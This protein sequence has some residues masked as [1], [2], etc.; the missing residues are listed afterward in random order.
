MGLDLQEA[1]NAR[2]VEDL[3][4]YQNYLDKY[5]QPL[6]KT[7]E[8]AIYTG[9]A[10]PPEYQEG[11]QAR[12]WSGAQAP[13]PSAASIADP[14]DASVAPP[15]ATGSSS[16]SAPSANPALEI[17]LDAAGN[18]LAGIEPPSTSAPRAAAAPPEV[19]APSPTAAAAD[20][21]A[22][23]SGGGPGTSTAKGA[24]AVSRQVARRAASGVDRALGSLDLGLGEAS[25]AGLIRAGAAAR[26]A[27]MPHLGRGLVRLGGVARY[28]APAMAA[29]GAVLPAVFGAMEGFNQ[30][31]VG[32]GVIQGGTSL[33]GAAAGA[34][35]G[36]AILPGIGTAIGAGLGSMA[37]SGVG[38]ALTSGAAGLVEKAQAG[39]TGWAGGIGRALDPFIDT[40]FEK[41]QTAALQQM[42]SPAMRLIRDQENA[43]L[44]RARADQA[45]AVLM[46][47]YLQE[48]R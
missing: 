12:A 46:Q 3:Y 34:A 28:A 18:S 44:E 2:I 42:N 11:F 33:G 21:L 15:V 4:D 23:L 45:Q 38:S 8:N 20:E 14:W 25:R 24:N 9:Q 22:N 26:S 13:P 17:A 43:R 7:V 10:L 32:G 35:I 1:H 41:Q 37:G 30:A 31:G 48:V 19:I 16:G 36:T 39:D 5:N 6:Y 40:A 47:A 27:G 29:G